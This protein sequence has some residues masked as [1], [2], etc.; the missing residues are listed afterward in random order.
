MEKE[1]E[2]EYE[3]EREYVRAVTR[4]RQREGDVP[5]V[6]YCLMHSSARMCVYVCV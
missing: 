4:G 3:I 1:G 2:A 6:T 5:V